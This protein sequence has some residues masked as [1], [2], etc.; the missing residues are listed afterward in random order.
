MVKIQPRKALRW[1]TRSFLRWR[2]LAC[3]V[4]VVLVVG[5]PMVIVGA[6]A[7]SSRHG[8]ISGLPARDVAIVFGAGLF[9]NGDLTPMLHDRMDGAIALLHEEKAHRLLLTGDNSRPDYSEVDAMA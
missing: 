2:V 6:E 4:A 1:W 9:P 5:L 3:A 8:S 7:G